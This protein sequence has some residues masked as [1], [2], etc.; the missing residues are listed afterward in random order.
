[1]AAG[2]A[3]LI[4]YPTSVTPPSSFSSC[5]VIYNGVTYSMGTCSVNTASNTISVANGLSVSIPA[6]ST[7][8]IVMNSITNPSTSNVALS[9]SLTSYTDSSYSYSVDTITSGLL[10]TFNC[11]YPC[12]ACSSFS[13]C[14]S[15]ITN[16]SSEPY[17][18]LSGNQCLKSCPNGQYT[19]SN[20]IC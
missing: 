5:S 10:P 19:D 12:L 15:C 18:Y 11:A 4:T 9:F 3:F 20:F 2:A 17:K 8:Q 16:S 1:M 14:T 7:I 6:G 13:A